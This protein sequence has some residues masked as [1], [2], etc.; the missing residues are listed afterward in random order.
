MRALVS[1]VQRL[2]VKVP[3]CLPH[4]LGTAAGVEEDRHLERLNAL[5][6]H[7]L[8]T[9]PAWMNRAIHDMTT[10]TTSQGGPGFWHHQTAADTSGPLLQTTPELDEVAVV[11]ALEKLGPAGTR[12]ADALRTL[13]GTELKTKGPMSALLLTLT[14]DD[15]ADLASDVHKEY[16]EWLGLASDHLG[17]LGTATRRDLT[18]ALRAAWRQLAGIHALARVIAAY[19]RGG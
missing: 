14:A 15:S 2:N 6:H 1:E 3:H 12:G 19:P 10:Q 17:T 5:E 9:T 7:H 8:R 18:V 4:L 11:R 13:P 16:R